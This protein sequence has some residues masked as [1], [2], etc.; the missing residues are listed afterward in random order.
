[1]TREAFGAHIIQHF[2][3][4][5]LTLSTLFMGSSLRLLGFKSSLYRILATHN[6]CLCLDLF[7][8]S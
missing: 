2:G 3:L 8:G 1:M 4:Y 5:H 7:P 6:S